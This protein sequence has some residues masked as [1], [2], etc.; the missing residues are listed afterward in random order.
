MR[1]MPGGQCRHRRVHAPGVSDTIAI[2]RRVIKKEKKEKKKKRKE[3]CAMK[4]P[5]GVRVQGYFTMWEDSVRAP[6]KFFSPRYSPPFLSLSLSFFTPSI[7]QPTPDSKSAPCCTGCFRCNWIS[8]FAL[9]LI[10]KIF[11]ATPPQP[12]RLSV[13]NV[14]NFFF[15]M[16]LRTFL[17]F[18]FFSFSF[19]SFIRSLCRNISYLFFK[20][21]LPFLNAKKD[22][23]VLSF[24]VVRILSSF[25]RIFSSF[26]F[27]F[28]FFEKRNSLASKSA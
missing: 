22:S 18:S 17:S 15:S 7:S 8:S 23:T 5:T 11:L 16:S 28:F 24:L 6:R 10:Y 2:E 9:T 1:K 14:F 19:L 3:A 21:L 20:L 13:R 25:L 27:F 12:T 4:K 26:I